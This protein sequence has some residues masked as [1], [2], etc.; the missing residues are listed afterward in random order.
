MTDILIIKLGA[1]GDLFQ[2]EGAFHD[3]RLHH[4]DAR[5]TVL[6]APAYRKLLERCPWVDEVWTD[7]RA[8]R[9]RLDRMLAL[10]R[11]LRSR[12][13]AMVYDLQNAARTAFYYRWF[14]PGTPWSGTA[15]GCSHP[16]RA[17]RPKRIPSLERL[18]GQLRDAGVTIHHT[19][20]PDLSWMAD[21]VSGVLAEAG[22]TPPFIVLLPGSSARLPHKRW[23]G[24][25]ALAQRLI[26]DGH[27]VVTVPGPDELDLCRTIPGTMLTGGGWLDYFQLAGVLKQAR[28][29]V[30]NDT[31]PSHLAAHLGVPLV[32]LLGAHT[33]PRMTGIDRPGV[34]CLEQADLSD[35]AV[36]RVYAAVTGRLTAETSLRTH[37]V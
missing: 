4:A 7:P 20:A 32:A 8:P 2:A 11:R 34:T 28:L 15:P 9:W 29:A 26:A 36:D 12:R 18:A 3:I 30:G 22:V 10:R 27:R 21:D 1:L 5:V 19:T 6:T 25:A 35:L 23:P 17:D 13:F 37:N 31:G 33:S 14:L 16:H 24:Y